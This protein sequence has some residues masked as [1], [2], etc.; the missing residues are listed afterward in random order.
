[1]INR[2][3]LRAEFARNGKTQKEVAKLIGVSEKTFVTRMKEGWFRTDEVE[4][5]VRELGIQ[6][7]VEVFFP[8]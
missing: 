4:I 2:N 1:M 7:I 6:N 5:M 3:A 8:S